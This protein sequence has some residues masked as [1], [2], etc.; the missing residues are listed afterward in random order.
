MVLA[1]AADGG[2]CL[3]AMKRY[4]PALFQGIAWSTDRVSSQTQEAGRRQGLSIQLLPEME[5]VDDAASWERALAHV[6]GL[7]ESL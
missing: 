7:R 6:P 5:D 4:E 1:P 3:L 2:Y